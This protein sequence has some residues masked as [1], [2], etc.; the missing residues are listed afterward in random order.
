MTQNHN[1]KGN[2]N[3]CSLNSSYNRNNKIINNSTLNT[4]N[5]LTKIWILDLNIHNKIKIILIIINLIINHNTAN[6]RNPLLNNKV[7]KGVDNRLSTNNI[8]VN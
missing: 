5:K 2:N 3:N 1:T 7:S 8:L 6:N 4:N